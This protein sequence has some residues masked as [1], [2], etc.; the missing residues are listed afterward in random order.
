MDKQM[1]TR[2]GDAACVASKARPVARLSSISTLR[3]AHSSILLHSRLIAAAC[4]SLAL[5]KPA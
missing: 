3:C 5:P 1:Q 2:G 4:I